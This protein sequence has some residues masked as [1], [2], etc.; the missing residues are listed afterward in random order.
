MTKRQ[1][2]SSYIAHIIADEPK[3]P[4]GDAVLSEQLNDD[5]SNLMLLCPD[6]HRRIDS[7]DNLDIY[8]V[9]L[10]RRMKRVHEERIQLVASLYQDKIS[11][12]ISYCPPIGNN[13]IV[14]NHS[15]ILQAI[16]PEKYPHSDIPIELSTYSSKI[17]D[18]KR[19]YWEYEKE[20]LDLAFNEQIKPKLANGMIKHLSVFAIAPQPLL[21]QLGTM[22]GDITEL[23]IYQKHREPSTWKWLSELDKDFGYIINKTKDNYKQVALNLSL[24]GTIDNSRIYEVLGTNTSIWTVTI[25]KT[26]NDF[27]RSK[28]QLA[29][30]RSIMRTLYEDIKA[31]HGHETILNVFPACPIA[32]AIEIGRVRMPKADMPL[33]I[34]DENRNI[35]GF[36]Y[37]LDIF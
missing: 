1:Y 9:E 10:L 19:I 17:Y 34:Y 22:L 5:I 24:S 37:A 16:F 13:N 6:C 2:N 21:I 7:K 15:E 29:Q 31:E 28:T 26:N 18:D 4:R 35:G 30:F 36:N 20:Q 33:R 27:L 14:L 23:D 8:T 11:H 25:N 32:I 12:V 3:G